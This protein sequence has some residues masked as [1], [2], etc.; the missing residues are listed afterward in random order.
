MDN[1]TK[2][3]EDS[4]QTTIK[5]KTL[6]SKQKGHLL[7][8]NSLGTISFGVSTPTRASS[9][10][11]MRMDRIMAKSLISFLAWKKIKKKGNKGLFSTIYIVWC[12]CLR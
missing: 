1:Y 7:T 10:Q 8:L 12:P 4:E 11:N 5:R 9:T 2:L 3:T 6:S